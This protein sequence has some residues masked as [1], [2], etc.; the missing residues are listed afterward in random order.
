MKLFAD[1]RSD[2]VTKPTDAMWDAMRAAPVGDDVLGDD[3]TVQELEQKSA[4]LMGKEAAVFVPSGTMGNQIAVAAHTCPG[5]AILVEDDAHILYYEVG[6]PAVFNGLIVRS[7]KGENGI[8][9]AEEVRARH[10]QFSLHTPGT[11]LLCLENTHNRAGGSVMTVQRHDEIRTVADELGLQIHL[12]GA[13]VFN[14]AA[15]LGCRVADITKH[16]DSVSFCLSKGLG[17]PVGSVVCG[18]EALILKAR[19]WRKRLGGGM[20]QSGLLAAAGIYALENN[21]A[22]LAEDHRRA[23]EFA[24]GL[25]GIPGLRPLQPETNIV[26]VDTDAPADR[27]ADFIEQAGVGTFAIGP[28]RLRFVFH[29][30]VGDEAMARALEAVRQTLTKADLAPA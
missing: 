1:L 18:T 28:N 20:R 9:T 8:V 16:V 4:E 19:I 5:D 3:P 17:T 26:I 2:T 12:D 22:L 24:N 15:A 11:T 7:M 29:F 27:L 14:A 6:G 23:K 21:V 30:Q 25:D 10:L 13:R